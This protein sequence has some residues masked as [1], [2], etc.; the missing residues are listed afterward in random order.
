MFVYDVY[1]YSSLNV[2]SFEGFP[3][4]FII[5]LEIE[6]TRVIVKDDTGHKTGNNLLS[7]S[8]VAALPSATE[9]L[10]SVFGMETCVS[11]RL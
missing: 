1:V 4:V 11:P 7:H 10:T 2:F 6:K 3:Y 5:F 9:G 8:S